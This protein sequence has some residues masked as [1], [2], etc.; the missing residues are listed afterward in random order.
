MFKKIKQLLIDY[1]PAVMVLSIIALSAIVV[2]VANV[3]KKPKLSAEYKLEMYDLTDSISPQDTLIVSPNLEYKP[4]TI[5][6]I[7][8][9]CTA[10]KE[11]I[12]PTQKTWTD[13]FYNV[14]YPGKKMVGYNYLVSDKEV[15]ELRPIDC[16]STLE[17]SEIVWGV[18]NYNSRT[19]SIAYVGGLS[20]AGKNKDTRTD[21]QKHAI[22]SLTRKIL[23]Y[24][25]KA[26]V[27]G[28]GSFPKVNK[29]CPNFKVEGY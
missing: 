25:P 3:V 17:Q 27:M 5:E 2:S 16:N 12:F 19:V 29:S 1:F 6:F 22:D 10:S 28:H 26:K 20:K 9:H 21:Y 23:V 8:L 13:F 24:S 18:S 14:K 11:G 15:F 7:A 4:K